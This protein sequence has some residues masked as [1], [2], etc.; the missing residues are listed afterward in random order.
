MIR[1]AALSQTTNTSSWL[2][3]IYTGHIISVENAFLS[4]YW[5]NWFSLHTTQISSPSFPFFIPVFHVVLHVLAYQI[6]LWFK[7]HEHSSCCTC[8]TRF[9]FDSIQNIKIAL[10][11]PLSSAYFRTNSLLSVVYSSRLGFG[12]VNFRHLHARPNNQDLP[13]RSMLSDPS[14]Y[15]SRSRFWRLLYCIIFFMF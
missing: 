4:Y 3:I 5:V 12:V 15:Q 2:M 13:D 9:D 11:V 14:I 10:F 7:K 1:T 6:T 8:G